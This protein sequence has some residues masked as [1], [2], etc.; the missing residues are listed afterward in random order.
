[1]KPNF[2]SLK[3]GLLILT[4]VT[5]LSIHSYAQDFSN[6]TW[7]A[8]DTSNTFIAYFHIGNDTLSYSIDNDNYSNIST[9]KIKYS[10]ISA[11]S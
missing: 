1:M 6:T 10:F 3:V 4:L 9:I 7:I 8:Y 5:T 11:N 2:I